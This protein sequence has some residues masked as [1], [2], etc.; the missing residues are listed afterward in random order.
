[1][2]LKPKYTRFRAYQLGQPGSLFSYYDGTGFTLI[3]AFITKDCIP[4]LKEEFKKCNLGKKGYIDCLHITSWDRDHCE[5]KSLEIIL[6]QLK[7]KRVEC[8]GYNP[9]SAK[10][11]QVDCFNLIKDYY[12]KNSQTEPKVRVFPFLANL[13][14][15][16]DSAKKWNYSNILYNNPKN[17]IQPNDNSSVK[18]FRT[19]CFSVLSLGDIDSKAN[20]DY[21][22][23]LRSIKNE[24]DV[25]LLAHHGSNNE[26]N[27]KE[28]FE[29]INPTLCVCSS[30]Y[31]NQFDHPI[32][33]VRNTL[34]ALNIPLKTSKNGDVIIETTGDDKS[35][36]S[37]QDLQS[38]NTVQRGSKINYKSKR[39]KQHE[40]EKKKSE[41][42]LIEAIRRALERGDL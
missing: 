13:I 14:S 21:L 40:K 17:N 1:M 27:T 39:A 34:L 31:D 37:V 35:N 11:N 25:L 41:E 7:P 9:D 5:R 18:L 33:S 24:V 16:L 15:A 2:E 42:D 28:F 20:K 19:G 10:Q 38:S 22:L 3:E 6:N 8:P 30:N 29:I 4:S 32:Q 26:V 12:K 36:F 23:K